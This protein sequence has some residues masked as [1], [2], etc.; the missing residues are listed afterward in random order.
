MT[1]KLKA[2]DKL[3]QVKDETVIEVTVDKVGT[4]FFY[5]KT[6]RAWH[7]PECIEKDLI[8]KTFFP[9]AEEAQARID[10]NLA[11]DNFLDTLTACDNFRFS[12]LEG[13][14][15]KDEMISIHERLQTVLKGTTRLAFTVGD[16]VK[17]VGSGAKQRV[18]SGRVI[19]QRERPGTE[20][21]VV[22]IVRYVRYGAIIKVVDNSLGYDREFYLASSDV[23]KA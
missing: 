21:R 1:A 4:K 16:M 20:L 18:R 14:L 23:R 6:E 17:V 15:S 5:L 2:G 19:D 10:L 22:E 9:T 11:M 12:N 7:K 8:G 13:V 3:F